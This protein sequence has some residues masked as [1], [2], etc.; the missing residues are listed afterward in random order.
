MAVSAV[1]RR[2]KNARVVS[3]DRTL[4]ALRFAL[5]HTEALSYTKGWEGAIADLLELG[6][7]NFDMPGGCHVVW[8]CRTGDFPSLLDSASPGTLAAAPD[9]VM[10]DA[11]SPARCPEMWTLKTLSRWPIH[12]PSG[13]SSYS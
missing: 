9:C 13:S 11:F 3:F 7:S 12:M 4:G 10:Y 6:E 8:E 2:C 5:L 1:H